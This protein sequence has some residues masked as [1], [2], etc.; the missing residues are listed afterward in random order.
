MP[1]S[2]LLYGDEPPSY[3]MDRSQIALRAAERMADMVHNDIYTNKLYD[4]VCFRSDV[5]MYAATLVIITSIDFKLKKY[6]PIIINI[7]NIKQE[8][9]WS[10]FIR[11]FSK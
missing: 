8:N 4:S 11:K 3:K 5:A 7:S 2:G 1:Y 10:R 6:N 9:C